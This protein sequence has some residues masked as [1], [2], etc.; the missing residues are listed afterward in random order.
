MAPPPPDL[1]LGARR[2]FVLNVVLNPVPLKEP[3]KIRVRMLV[4]GDEIKLG[5]LNVK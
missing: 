3:G 4:D 5:T 2:I 1:E